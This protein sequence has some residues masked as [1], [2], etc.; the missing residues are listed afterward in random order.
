MRE[1]VLNKLEI[2]DIQEG[3]QVTYRPTN[4]FLESGASCP[5]DVDLSIE[6][7]YRNESS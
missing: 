5:S 4:E 6:E 7:G 3:C 1:E 2:S